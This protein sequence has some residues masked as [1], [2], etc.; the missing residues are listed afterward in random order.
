[1][2][3]KQIHRIY[4]VGIGGIGMSA[5]ARFFH[6]KGVAVSGY[7]R[8]STQLT[9]QLEAEGIPIHYT[10]DLAQIDKAANLV[11]YTP[12]IPATQKEL[13]YYR[14][15]GY[16]VVK[17]SD[18]LQEITRELFAIT[19]A[20]T[21]GKTTVSTMVA[22]LL[23]H[24]GYG[25]NAF[26]GG[27]SSNYGKNFWSSEKPVAVIEA[28]EYDRSFLKLNPDIALLTAMDP[29]HL[30]IYGTPA[31]VEAA[32]IQYTQNIKPNGTLLAR[33]G[34]PRGSELK[35]DNKLTY[36]LQNDAADIYATNIRMDNGGYEFDVM[37]QGWM[38]DNVQLHIGGMHNVE[39]AVAAIGVAHLLGISNDK[40]RTAVA[41]F[42]GIRRR[43]EYLVKKNRVV[44]IDDYAHH[45]EEL[46]ALITSAKSLFRGKKCTVI[47][48]PHLFTRTRDFADGFAET[49][50]LADEVVLLPIYPARELPI[51]GVT[52]QM[53]A[54]RI[55]GPAVQVIPRDEVPAWLEKQPAELVITAGAGD[56]DLLREPVK[57]ILASR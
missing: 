11:V 12:A 30:D 19:V 49:L 20:G 53:I 52:S 42:K 1:M 31:E 24:S 47:F 7:D 45:P 37:Q 40:I 33:H 56:I 51:E 34:L 13:V 35:G 28:D 54:G 4:F 38:I 9:Q 39:N 29:D 8:T 23:R 50:A 3:L 55:K 17:R 6:E 22:H 48:Q 27:I 15:N 25:C 32:F 26:L 18:V 14:E 43:F 57:E 46:R 16:K 41:D 10:E 44:Y 21:H 5:I 36:S 2:E